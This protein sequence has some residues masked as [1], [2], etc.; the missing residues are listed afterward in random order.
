MKGI[1]VALVPIGFI[2]GILGSSFADINPTQITISPTCTSVG[3]P[4]TITVT[5][6]QTGA[7]FKY[8]VRENSYCVSGGQAQ[9][10][11]IQD[12]TTDTTATW[13]PASPGRKTV[14]VWVTDDVSSSCIGMIGASYEVGGSNCIDP[15]S[16]S[17]S[18]ATGNV[19]E[20]VTMT[21]MAD[22]ILTSRRCMKMTAR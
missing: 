17:L 12:W 16:V 11:M 7:N 10:T 6:S 5:G 15:A 21:V 22:H 14:V 4:V 2:L 1:V 18:P 8:W 13:T 9:W 20:A 19:N 3:S